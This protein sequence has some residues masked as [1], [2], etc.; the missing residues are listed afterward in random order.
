MEEDKPLAHSLNF[1]RQI[2]EDEASKPA[3][4]MSQ[5]HSTSTRGFIGSPFRYA[6][7]QE[8]GV[9]YI[10]VRGFV[11]PKSLLDFATS[12]AKEVAT[13]FDM[14]VVVEVS[15]ETKIELGPLGALEGL[16][17]RLSEILSG[18]APRVACVGKSVPH[19]TIARAWV[20]MVNPQAHVHAFSS[21]E[22][23]L[24]WLGFTEK[25][26]QQRLLRHLREKAR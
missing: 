8:A 15:K 13:Q 10:L 1:E 4:K 25:Q 11:I 24:A 17:E 6:I 12:Y 16:M 19:Q 7:D 26:E 9:F 18:Q 23:A 5:A 3:S 22:E 2:Q 21:A 14:D 20:Q